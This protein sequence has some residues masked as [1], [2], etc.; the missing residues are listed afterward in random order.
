[1]NMP[2]G[3][4]S[5]LGELGIKSEHA[6]SR[7]W[8]DL[9]NGKLVEAAVDAGFT[10][11]LTRPPI[12]RVR[13]AGAQP[14][15]RFRGG[16][17]DATAASLARIPYGLPPQLGR[18]SDP[19]RSRTIVS[20]AGVSG[21]CAKFRWRPTRSQNLVASIS[22]PSERGRPRHQSKSSA[23]GTA[24]SGFSVR[25]SSVFRIPSRVQRQ[26]VRSWGSRIQT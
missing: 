24:V 19:A 16:A 8:G 7:G 23:T 6:A 22:R 25:S 1:M 5:A 2:K 12:W 10:C 18:S 13:I 20:M 17:G 9:K 26:A 14:I 3:L 21:I 11:L 4:V 15:S